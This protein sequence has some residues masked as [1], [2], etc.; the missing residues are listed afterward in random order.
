[1][2]LTAAPPTKIA[3]SI[4]ISVSPTSGRVPFDITVTGKLVDSAGTGLN[5][6]TINL[7]SN[8]ILV[9]TTT[10]ILNG[11]YAFNLNITAAG[12]YQFQTE[13]LGDATYEGCAANNGTIG[14]TEA[15]AF[16][17]KGKA[18]TFP[19]PPGSV[20]AVVTVDAVQYKTPFEEEIPAGTK[21][22]KASWNT[23]T[24]EE[25]VNVDKDMTILFLFDPAGILN[26]TL[27]LP[28][29]MLPPIPLP[30]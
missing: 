18:F 22:F 10:T 13:F 11:S 5:N 1:V 27:V 28:T 26:R 15:G 3:T 25:E 30:S 9:G 6:K 21:I 12:T 24:L 2:T 17:V 20:E 16:T 19:I 23:Q 29:E 14:V 8:V 7:Y 4:S